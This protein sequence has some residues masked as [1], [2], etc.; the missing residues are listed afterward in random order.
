[1]FGDKDQCYAIERK[2][3][4]TMDEN[5]SMEN[6]KW[7]SKLNREFARCWGRGNGDMLL[8]GYSVL[9]TACIHSEGKMHIIA[10]VVNNTVLYTRSLFKD[11]MSSHKKQ[12][13]K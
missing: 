2:E 8:K 11:Y 7:G 12:A 13:E 10:T 1:M 6:Q 3:S 5:G 9:V 4:V